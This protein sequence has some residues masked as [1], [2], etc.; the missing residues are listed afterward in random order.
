MDKIE[1]YFFLIAL[2]VLAVFLI[3]NAR[4][5]IYFSWMA[6]S[7]GEV[8][9]NLHRMIINVIDSPNYNPNNI[10]YRYLD[11][12]NVSLDEKANLKIYA[13][14]RFWFD[15]YVKFPDEL[16][17][18]LESKIK[19]SDIEY[20]KKLKY[21]KHP[22][23]DETQVELRIIF[24]KIKDKAVFWAN[25]KGFRGQA[26]RLGYF[27]IKAGFLKP[28]SDTKESWLKIWNDELG[29]SIEEPLTSKDLIK[30]PWADDANR[31]KNSIDTNLKDILIFFYD[32]EWK[33]GVKILK[34][35]MD[36]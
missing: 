17:A 21:S 3:Y 20:F 11:D 12:K 29:Q 14:R 27:V 31:S 10:I 26:V 7:E 24:E 22:R 35:G 30:N 5:K 6:D 36:Q 13:A 1:L 18:K 34:K 28:E 9:Y 8:Y 4:E 25:S 23:Y 15:I 33:K 32:I 19:L 2:I 16:L